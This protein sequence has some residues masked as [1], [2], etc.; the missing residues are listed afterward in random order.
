MNRGKDPGFPMRPPQ[1]SPK[2]REKPT[3]AH[4][5]VVVAMDMRHCD[6]DQKS[7][8]IVFKIN[9]VMILLPASLW[10]APTFGEPIPRKKRR[11]R[12]AHK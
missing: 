10:S 12:A 8:M 2:T 6:E 4:A 5:I 7:E 3:K 11:D 1:L 9:G